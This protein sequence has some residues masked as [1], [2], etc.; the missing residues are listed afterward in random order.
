MKH[1]PGAPGRIEAFWRAMVGTPLF[2]NHPVQHREG[3]RNLAIPISLHTDAVPVV[4]VGK[5]W[6]KSMD[7][8]SWSSLL[9]S[10]TTIDFMFFVWAV[11]TQ[12]LAKSTVGNTDEVFWRK[13]NWSLYWLWRGLWPDEDDFGVKYTRANNPEAF[14]KKTNA[15]R[16]WFFLRPLGDQSRSR[17]LVR[18]HV[19]VILHP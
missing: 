12:L 2:Q 15:T 3:F 19:N 18:T 1:S 8:Y 9:G 16:W 4:G 6:Q 11:F 14:N 10:G 5:S 17:V 7:C 13:F